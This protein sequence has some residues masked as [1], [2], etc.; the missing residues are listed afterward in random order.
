ME[1]MSGSE[2]ID[3]ERRLSITF[4]VV[5]RCEQIDRLAGV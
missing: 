5:E 1:V 2:A 3:V 4:A